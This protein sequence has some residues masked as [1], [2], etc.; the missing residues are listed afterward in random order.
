MSDFDAL[1]LS[2]RSVTPTT[3]MI[4]PIAS[5]GS[6]HGAI[7]AP[8]AKGASTPSGSPSFG[9]IIAA[10]SPATSRKSSSQHTQQD[11]SGNLPEPPDAKTQP[12]QFVL[13]NLFGRFILEADT[14]MNALLYLQLVGIWYDIVKS[15][16]YIYIHLLFC[17]RIGMWIC[18]LQSDQVKIFHL[19]VYCKH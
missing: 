1:F 8:Q 7:N 18:L 5:S 3:S 10:A 9:A 17:H 16:S 12:S 6:Y 14:K 2:S 15:L 11:S 13:H 19:I 4:L